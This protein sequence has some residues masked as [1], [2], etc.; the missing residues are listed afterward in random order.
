MSSGGR[1]VT[2]WVE[3]FHLRLLNVANGLLSPSLISWIYPAA[4]TGRYVRGFCLSHNLCHPRRQ[5]P[6]Y[7]C[8]GLSLYS[9]P[10]WTHSPTSVP[11]SQGWRPSS[12]FLLLPPLPSV[13]DDQL[14]TVWM[15]TQ[16]ALLSLRC[17][18]HL[19]ILVALILSWQS[20]S[21]SGIW[22]SLQ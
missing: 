4:M 12:R 17:V 5:Q 1:G 2:V 8:P 11:H 3:I 18:S 20:H 15:M 7:A 14:L 22:S 21:S 13:P 16:L 19:T 6:P 9:D 10:Q